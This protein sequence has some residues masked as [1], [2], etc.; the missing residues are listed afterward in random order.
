MGEGWQ[1]A[2]LEGDIS[3]TGIPYT[4]R[5]RIPDG[6]LVPP[7]WHA[8]EEY[9]TVIEGILVVGFGEKV[10]PATEVEL[11]A[12]SY[13]VMPR[14]VRHYVWCKGETIVQMQG[15][16]PFLVNWANPS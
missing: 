16:G 10:D 14:G 3:Q 7:H 11:P 4:M 5:T 12:G 9:L 15:T 8:T 1:L 13:V 6:F 2:V